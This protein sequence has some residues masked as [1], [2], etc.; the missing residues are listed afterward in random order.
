MSLAVAI[1]MQLMLTAGTLT[2]LLCAGALALA[3]L[4]RI[5]RP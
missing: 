1:S 4:S 2:A 3:T 5:G